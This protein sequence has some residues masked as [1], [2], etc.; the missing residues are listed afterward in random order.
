[1]IFE[2][3]I[4]VVHDLCIKKQRNVF[5]M[6]QCLKELVVEKEQKELKH[7]Q[8]KLMFDDRQIVHAQTRVDFEKV[9]DDFDVAQ[10]GVQESSKNFVCIDGVLV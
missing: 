9:K 6:K 3:I 5:V 4:K 2:S 1:M 10:L 7:W 8:A